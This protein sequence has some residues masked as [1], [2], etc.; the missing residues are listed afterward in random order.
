MSKK[1]KKAAEACRGCRG[2]QRAAEAAGAAGAAGAAEG[3]RGL[4][5]PTEACSWSMDQG[6]Y[7]LENCPLLLVFRYTDYVLVYLLQSEVLQ[8][9][10]QANNKLICL[11]SM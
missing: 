10:V 9:T 3:C 5:R 4:Q 11:I 6:P 1:R 2:L 8:Y 7:Y